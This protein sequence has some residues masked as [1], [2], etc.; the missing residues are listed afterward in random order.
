M[1]FQSPDGHTVTSNGD[2]PGFGPDD[3]TNGK[4]PRSRARR[5]ASNA[6]VG[7]LIQEFIVCAICENS[8][9]TGHRV[10]GCRRFWTYNG[11]WLGAGFGS[12]SGL[13]SQPNV[14]PPGPF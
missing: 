6:L 13:P 2:A 11:D 14:Q 12:G 4:S 3:G 7:P 5:F 10:L 1:I 9:G 8:N